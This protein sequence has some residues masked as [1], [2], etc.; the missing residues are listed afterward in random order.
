MTQ[1]KSPTSIGKS[2]P[3]LS[4]SIPRAAAVTATRDFTQDFRNPAACGPTDACITNSQGTIGTPL[5]YPGIASALYGDL[6]PGDTEVTLSVT[7][8][9]TPND[10]SVYN[11]TGLTI[12]PRFYVYAP[13]IPLGEISNN[14]LID[15]FT[16]QILDP[17]GQVLYASNECD[18]RWQWDGQLYELQDCFSFSSLDV[19]DAK[20]LTL[21]NNISILSSEIVQFEALIASVIVHTTCGTISVSPLCQNVGVWAGYQYDTS[22]RTIARLGCG[23]TSL[24]MALN[25][26]GASVGLSTGFTPGQ[27]NSLA[28]ARHWYSGSS[29]DWDKFTRNVVPGWKFH[30]LDRS[31]S[32]DLANLLCQGY[33]VIVG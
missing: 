23:L 8:M 30:F 1:P 4:R 24:T 13:T 28:K 7:L 10:T 20:A 16:F 15:A 6:Q 17:G 31:S 32:Q 9:L 29:V 27:L 19:Q 22:G 12:D 3:T 26:Y 11:I 33:P 18:A 2:R 5:L 25:T 14:D 21:T